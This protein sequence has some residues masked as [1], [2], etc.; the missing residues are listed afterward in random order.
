MKRVIARSM[1]AQGKDVVAV[2][3][4]CG[5]SIALVDI[6]VH[7]EC[8]L[9]NVFG[10]EH[11]GGQDKVVEEA[12][13]FWA[14]SKGMVG[15]SSDVHGHPA[16]RSH[17]GTFRGALHDDGFALDQGAG[18]FESRSALVGGTEYA[19]LQGLPIFRGVAE[20]DVMLCHGL[21][22]DAIRFGHEAFEQQLPIQ[23]RIF[24]HREAMVGGYGVCI[25]R[26]IGDIHVESSEMREC[27]NGL[28]I[29]VL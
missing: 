23:Q 18:P 15:A 3:G 25:H 8:A 17:E 9:R 14:I 16:L 22:D 28:Y 4:Q 21:G 13:A 20:H 6:E 5:C 2:R 19:L 29:R 27:V 7:N 26:V 24:V 11:V 12:E 1:E 10:V